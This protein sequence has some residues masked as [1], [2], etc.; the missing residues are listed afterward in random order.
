MTGSTGLTLS[1]D[2]QRAT[3]LRPTRSVSSGWVCP[4]MCLASLAPR[5]R[6]S[7]RTLLRTRARRPTATSACSATTTRRVVVGHV[8]LAVTLPRRHHLQ[9]VAAAAGATSVAMPRFFFFLGG[10]GGCRDN[11]IVNPSTSLCSTTYASAIEA[12]DGLSLM[13]Y[14]SLTHTQLCGTKHPRVSSYSRV[15]YNIVHD[16]AG[17]TWMDQL[18]CLGAECCVLSMKHQLSSYI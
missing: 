4:R 11:V 13:V 12:I 17:A 9:M 6:R 14:H 16:G 3:G 10:E 15:S 18:G 2:R 1:T 8:S 5:W 7:T